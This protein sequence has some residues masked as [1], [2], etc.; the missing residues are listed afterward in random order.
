MFELRAPSRLY[1][2]LLLADSPM[3]EP[4]CQMAAAN[5]EQGLDLLD[6]E[7]VLPDDVSDGKL[8]FGS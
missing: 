8:S 4:F 6:D 3:L 7:L 1:F 5:P 2:I